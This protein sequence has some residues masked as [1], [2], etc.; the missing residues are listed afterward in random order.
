MAVNIKK[1][2]GNNR[3]RKPDITSL[4]YGKVPPQ[5]TELE[6]AVLG[7]IM[8]EKEKL[9]DVMGIIPN[10]DVFYVDA[11]QKIYAAIQRIYN[12]GGMVDLLTVTEELRCAG[13]L[14]IIGG[15]YYLTRLTMNVVSS[16]HVEA[17]CKIVK[18]KFQQRELIRICGDKIARAY[19]DMDIP[20]VSDLVSETEREVSNLMQGDIGTDPVHI[21]QVSA[22]VFKEKSEQREQ[23]IETTGIPTGFPEMDRILNG[24][25]KTDLVILAAR[26]AVGKTAFSL[27]LADAA[28]SAGFPTAIFSLEMSRKQLVERR[29]AADTKIPLDSIK[30]PTRMQDHEYMHYG[31]TLSRYSKVPIFID[32]SAGL[33]MSQLRAKS[34]RLKAKQG[35]ELIII[36]YLQLMQG[37]KSGNREQE[38]SGLTRDIKCLAKELEIPIIALSQLN[39][40]LETRQDKKPKLSDLRESG[41]IEQD[42]D[43]VVL[44][45]RP[46]NEEEQNMDITVR[47]AVEFIIAKH[48]GGDTGEVH[49]FFERTIQKWH[50]SNPTFS[51]PQPFTPPPNPRAGMPG[52]TSYKPFNNDEI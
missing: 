37:D 40:G 41:A 19:D 4:V 8:L 18:A 47:G 21:S 33:S 12:G 50:S 32:D 35:I 26:P 5:A 15:A 24:W 13:E 48:R 23:G 14:E 34:R 44:I 29:H 27:E 2:F 28:A 3:N 9:S 31:N 51:T 36:D 45:Y 6:E 30:N 46:S 1:E 17:H 7:A 39:R 38:V 42:A 43:L 20:D 16:A 11:H 49:L 52:Y 22:G 25:Q 10:P